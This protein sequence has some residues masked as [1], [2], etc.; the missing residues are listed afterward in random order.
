MAAGMSKRMGSPKMLL[1]FQGKTII[2]HVIDHALCSA[3]D[4]VVVVVNPAVDG[5]VDEASV[6]GVNKVILNSRTDDGLSTSVKS[7]LLF[8]PLKVEAVLFMLGDQPLIT[9]KEIDRIVHRF[10]KERLAP[11]YQSSYLGKKG[12]PV[13][14]KRHLFGDLYNVQGDEGGRAV[15]KKYHQHVRLVEMRKRNPSDIDTRNDYE[16]LL[17]EEVS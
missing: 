7:G 13:L 5:L 1:P 2:R 16:K 12:H 10:K 8:L 17:D 14:F 3:L 11:I 9:N 6:N 15:L 4:G